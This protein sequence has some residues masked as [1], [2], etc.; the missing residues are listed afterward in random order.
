M[1][2]FSKTAIIATTFGMVNADPLID[3]LVKGTRYSRRA[4]ASTD[5]ATEFNDW[6]STLYTEQSNLE[7]FHSVENLQMVEATTLGTDGMNVIATHHSDYANYF[8]PEELWSE[9]LSRI[10]FPGGEAANIYIKRDFLPAGSKLSVY[11]DKRLNEVAGW[12][13]G[14]NEENYIQQA[15]HAENTWSGMTDANSETFYNTLKEGMFGE[16]SELTNVGE[17][18]FTE[19][20]NNINNANASN[21]EEVADVITISMRENIVEKYLEGSELSEFNAQFSEYFEHRELPHQA[22]FWIVMG[23]FIFIGLVWTFNYSKE[24]MV[25]VVFLAGA[26]CSTGLGFVSIMLYDRSE[27]WFLGFIGM[28]LSIVATAII[29]YSSC[30][31]KVEAN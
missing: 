21:G 29:L 12:T 31:K 8:S 18:N 26:V 23:L 6:K 19:A 30:K 4:L 1:V 13:D 11:E 10:E 24:G 15:Q 14:M 27:I 3:L 9:G 20:I 16:K 7:G 22:V 25:G 2:S 5:Y 17:Y 28:G